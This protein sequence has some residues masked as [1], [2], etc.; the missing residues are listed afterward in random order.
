MRYCNFVLYTSSQDLF[1]EAK[2]RERRGS[3]MRR[4]DMIRIF[5]DTML[6][7]DTNEILMNKINYSMNHNRVISDENEYDIFKNLIHGH[8]TSKDYRF[9]EKKL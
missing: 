7:C 8:E 4:E 9:K 3:I 5:E 6:L 2:S 1:S